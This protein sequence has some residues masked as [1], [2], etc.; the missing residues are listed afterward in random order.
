VTAHFDA[1]GMLLPDLL[2]SQARWQGEKTALICDEARRSWREFGAAVR[3]VAGALRASGVAPGE[4]VVVLM[5]NGLEMVEAMFGTLRAGACVVPLNPSVPD[6]AI[7]AMVK[8]SGATAVI[9]VPAHA[10]RFDRAALPG[11]RLWVCVDAAIRSADATRSTAGPHSPEAHWTDFAA[12]RDACDPDIADAVAM[13]PI[14]PDAPCNII[15]SSG[16]TGLPKGIVHSHARRLEWARG[17]AVA[18]RYRGGAVAIV[19]I[20]LYSNIS[21]ISL[22]CTFLVGG[23]VVIEREFDAI[24]IFASI[25]KHR[26]SHASLVPVIV[27]RMLE[28]PA[29]AE[30]DLGSMRAIMC[31][32]SPLALPLKQRA[33]TDF[34]C[35][36]IELYGLT[37]GVITTLEPEEAP[38]RLASVG[39]PLPGTEIRILGEGDQE[40][41]VGESGEIV[42]RGYITMLG[43]HNRA[44]AN[45][46]STWIDEHGRRWL[47]T[48]DVGRI[49]AEGYL[50]VVDRKKDMIIS[51]GQNIYPADIEAVLATHGDI[52]E[53]AVIG[54]PSAKWGETPLAIVVARTGAATDPRQA[55]NLLSWVNGRVGRQQR[56]A[57]VR[58]VDALPRN[59]N[60]K[61][62]KRELRR[63]HGDALA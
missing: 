35:D 25:T 39:K 51:G 50:Y 24:D 19:P 23:T 9:T 38:P 22:L 29:L 28:S 32:G 53:A 57:G 34:Q 37:E 63:T 54:V 16:T 48:G 15:Y 41:S 1:P 20:G 31:C 10:G 56:L 4:R 59:P 62:L 3:R 44:D 12:W 27:Q 33:L 58:F 11:V 40:V 6:P 17:L 60:G 55:E 47:R 45:A 42:S 30:A 43:Y 5:S 18:L 8:D 52:A 46:E 13:E 61:I 26:V 7:A 36:F 14:D 49:D 2:D 21:W